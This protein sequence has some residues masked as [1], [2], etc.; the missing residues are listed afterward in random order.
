MD[1]E[2]R[3]RLIGLLLADEWRAVVEALPVER[4]GWD[5]LDYYAAIMAHYRLGDPATALRLGYEGRKRYPSAPGIVDRM[6]LPMLRAGRH[7]DAIALWK[8]SRPRL[9]PETHK[10]AMANLV[11]NVIVAYAGAQRVQEGI[12]ELSDEIVRWQSPLLHGNAACL[13]ALADDPARALGYMKLALDGGKPRAFFEQDH[14]FD[15]IRH[16][17]EFRALLALPPL[18]H[19]ARG[20]LGL[21]L[22]SATS[23]GAL[24]WIIHRR[25]L[26]AGR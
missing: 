4:D 11:G 6:L 1:L 8:A 21:E 25:D 5:E 13:Y 19:A 7:R 24:A 18:E 22:A 15:R 26:L 2:R 12:A 23:L 3:R 16:L 14:D 20:S 9:W 10:E 17:P